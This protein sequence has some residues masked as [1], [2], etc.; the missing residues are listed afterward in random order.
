MKTYFEGH[1]ATI[2]I[3]GKRIT[4]TNMNKVADNTAEMVLN[5]TELLDG[6]ANLPEELFAVVDTR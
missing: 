6:T 3:K 5:F 4:E 2:R 1:T